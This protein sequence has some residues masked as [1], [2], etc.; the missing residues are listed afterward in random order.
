MDQVTTAEVFIR[1]DPNLKIRDAADIARRAK[2]ALS[3][4]IHDLCS[5]DVHLGN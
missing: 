3:S 2:K 4:N 1:V 5:A